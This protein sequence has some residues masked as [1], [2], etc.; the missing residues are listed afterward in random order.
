MPVLLRMKKMP[1]SLIR[2]LCLCREA[3]IRAYAEEQHYQPQRKRC[4][5]DT[6]T[7]RTSIRNLYN[8]MEALNPELRYSL[9]HA[10]ERDNKLIEL[11]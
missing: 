6:D 4:P 1:L 11:S 2:P 8:Q 5:Y 9:W 7:H 3:D 10:L